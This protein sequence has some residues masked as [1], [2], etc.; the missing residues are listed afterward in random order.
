MKTS[1]RET[2]LEKEARKAAGVASVEVIVEN[3]EVGGPADTILETVHA[4]SELETLAAGTDITVAP[5][6]VIPDLTFVETPVVTPEIELTPAPLV[7]F[8]ETEVVTPVVAPK[9]ATRRKK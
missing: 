8:V 7:A 6:P 3:T 1:I 9:K 5:T 2:A 4:T